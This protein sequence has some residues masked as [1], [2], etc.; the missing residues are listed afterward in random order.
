MEYQNTNLFTFNIDEGSRIKNTNQNHAVD[1]DSDLN[2]KAVTTSLAGGSGGQVQLWQ[3]LLEMLTD[4]DHHDDI[5][6][7]GDEGEFKL[8]APEKVAKQWGKR[9][10]KENM[11]YDKLSRA[12][13]YY[14][15]G[16]MLGK[17]HGK[18]FVYKFICD[19][20][21]LI[22]YSAAELSQQMS[23]C[24]KRREELKRNDDQDT[25][26]FLNKS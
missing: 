1:I 16:K 14:Y 13:R 24:V 22:G 9:K 15:D 25:N 2:H 4:V 10:G 17:V 19:L 26:K 11:N 23:E 12:L 5:K 8:L 21:D 18:R 7:I 6:W 3:F 20:R